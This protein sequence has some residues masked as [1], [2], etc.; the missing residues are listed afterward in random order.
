[1]KKKDKKQKR[2]IYTVRWDNYL[3][4]WMLLREDVIIS[5]VAVQREA[6]KTGREWA[7]GE[8]VD[9][10]TLT[11]LVVKRKNGRF[12]YERTYGKDPARSPG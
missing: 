8:H 5:Q 7:R 3:K 4:R 11:Q 12:G 1:M 9:M 6:V 10:R 2:I